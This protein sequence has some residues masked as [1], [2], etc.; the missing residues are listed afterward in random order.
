MSAEVPTK[1]TMRHTAYNRGFWASSGWW[2]PGYGAT[3][4]LSGLVFI[5]FDDDAT[6]PF[7]EEIERPYGEFIA[8][9]TMRSSVAYARNRRPNQRDGNALRRA[10]LARLLIQRIPPRPPLACPSPGGACQPS[11]PRMMMR[12]HQ[13]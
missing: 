10:P 5:G 2:M 6:D 4:L 8:E 3:A 11:C 13:D 7:H 9:K 1:Y 12:L